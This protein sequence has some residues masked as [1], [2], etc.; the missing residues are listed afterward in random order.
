MK[1]PV[2]YPHEARPT[3]A[4]AKAAVALRNHVPQLE[5]ERL[6]LRAPTLDD[7]AVYAE[8]LMS[9]R[10][11]YMDGPHNREDTWLDFTSS[12]SNWLLRGH[13]PWTITDKNTHEVLGFV[14]VQLEF[15]D[16]EPELGFFLRAQSEGNGIAFEA[17][18]AARKYA[19]ETL[20]LKHLVSYVDPANKRCRVLA[21]RLGG[22]EDRRAAMQFDDFDH[23]PILVYRYAPPAQAHA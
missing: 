3:G 22:K 1:T 4:A 10:A 18:Q 11:E 20:G 6:I 19:L 23:D 12:I 7:F 13:G 5:T 16:H 14:T 21:T 15:G 8:I 9:E 2:T 17:A